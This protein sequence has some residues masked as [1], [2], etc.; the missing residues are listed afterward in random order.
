L[1]APAPRTTPGRCRLRRVAGRRRVAAWE[2]PD[3]V[4]WSKPAMA[5][6][7]RCSTTAAAVRSMVPST[8]GTMRSVPELM[9]PGSEEAEPGDASEDSHPVPDESTL[10]GKSGV[11]EEVLAELARAEAEMSKPSGDDSD[12]T[13]AQV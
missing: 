10:L 11:Q 3:P 12:A 5:P 1:T 2:R 13:G 4:R 8:S 6:P 9:S 7:G